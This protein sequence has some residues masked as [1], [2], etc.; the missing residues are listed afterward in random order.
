MI[1]FMISRSL[2]PRFLVVF[3]YCFKLNV[4]V[5]HRCKIRGYCVLQRRNNRKN[6]HQSGDTNSNNQHSKNGSQQLCWMEPSAIRIF[7]LNNF[8]IIAV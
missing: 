3:S 8:N 1:G 7:S 4:L 2:P 5:P 6:T